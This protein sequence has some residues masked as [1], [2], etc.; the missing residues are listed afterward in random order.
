MVN[1]PDLK[2]LRLVAPLGTTTAKMWIDSVTL[3]PGCFTC[4]QFAQGFKTKLPQVAIAVNID[5][6]CHIKRAIWK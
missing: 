6:L 2:C 1:T 4:C 5:I 3:S